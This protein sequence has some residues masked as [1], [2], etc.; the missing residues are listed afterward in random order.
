MSSFLPDTDTSIQVPSRP[1]TTRSRPPVKSSPAE[2][3]GDERTA[4]SDV[5][6]TGLNLTMCSA[7]PEANA[8]EASTVIT[9]QNMNWVV[10][11]M[12]ASPWLIRVVG[13]MNESSWN[14]VVPCVLAVKVRAEFRTNVRSLTTM[15]VVLYTMMR[16]CSVTVLALV[17][18]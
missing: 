15:P 14:A 11:K 7:T 16:N 10:L 13:L 9:E 18:R 6:A 5:P 1:L 3:A 2:T 8:A 12:N 17:Q 4:Y